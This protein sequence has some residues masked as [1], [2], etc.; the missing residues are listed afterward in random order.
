M[1]SPQ[2]KIG[3][4]AKGFALFAIVEIPPTTCLKDELLKE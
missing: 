4:L 3:G 2:P 1:V